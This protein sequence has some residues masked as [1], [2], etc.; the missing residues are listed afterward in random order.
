M[1]VG[2]VVGDEELYEVFVELLDLVIEMCYGGYKKIDQYKIDFDFM[3][4]KGGKFDENYVL[5]LCVCIGCFIWGFFLLLYC[6]C[7]E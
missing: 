7:V 3:K 1:I 4:I 2:C 6:I 5:L